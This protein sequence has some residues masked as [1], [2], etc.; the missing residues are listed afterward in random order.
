MSGPESDGVAWRE[1]VAPQYAVYLAVACLGVWLHAADELIVATISP[2]MVAEIGG[3]ELIAWNLAIYEIGSIVAGAVSALL[4]MRMGVRL[5]MA[6]AALIFAVGCAVAA[7]AS[8]MWIVVLGRLLQGLGGG[9]LVAMSYIAVGLFFPQRLSARVMAA[10]SALWGVSAFL[11]PLIGGLFVEFSTWRGAF[12]FFAGQAVLL[13]VFVLL[14]LKGAPRSG[15][16]SADRGVPGLRLLALS[17]GVVSIAFA[18]TATEPWRMAAFILAGV[19]FLVLFLKLDAAAGER[20]L[21]PRNPV[22]LRGGVGAGLVMIVAFAAGTI[23][24]SIYGPLL[25]TLLHGTSVLVAGYVVACSSV[26]WSIVAVI[27]SGRPAR[28][29][30]KFILAGM[31]MVTLSIPGLIYAIPNGPLWLIALFAFF[32][33]GGFGMAWTFILRRTTALAPAGETERVAGAIPTVQRLG[34]AVGAA[35]LGI[36]ANAAGLAE[37]ASP[38]V[39]GAVSDAIFLASLPFALLGLFAAWRFVRRA[40]EPVRTLA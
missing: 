31:L 21:L 35:V 32:E 23:A 33:G 9:G 29:D 11:G 6:T 22:S 27:V 36:V 37:G 20:R 4:A 39:A 24:I 17:A 40:P 5:P 34:Y 10:I 7:T 19:A 1:I 16:G 15:T 18:G 25:I 13:S 30:P 3:A 26:G 14:V 2:A 38:S 8:A 28:H 12:W